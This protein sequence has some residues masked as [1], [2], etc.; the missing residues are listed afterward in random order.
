MTVPMYMR[1]PTRR[2]FVSKAEQAREDNV[3]WTVIA[4]IPSFIPFSMALGALNGAMDRTPGKAARYSANCS[5]CDF[6]LTCWYLDSNVSDV[7]CLPKP[8]VPK[9]YMLERQDWD[10]TQA[11]G[12][13]GVLVEAVEGV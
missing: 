3:P 11:W 4:L 12:W 8:A 2:H 6:V 1:S 7:E 10:K 13:T 5:Q 9:P